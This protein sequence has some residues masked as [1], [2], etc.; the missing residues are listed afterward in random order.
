MP[1]EIAGNQ[2]SPVAPASPVASPQGNIA[3]QA[4]QALQ[5]MNITPSPEEEV[6]NIGGETA[7]ESPSIDFDGLMNLI[8]N[9]GG[10]EVQTQPEVPAQNSSQND[11]AAIL[12]AMVQFSQRLDQIENGRNQSYYN[13]QQ[14]NF[15]NYQSQNQTNQNGQVQVDL[16]DVDPNIAA[17]QR[18]V[19]TL[20]GYIAQGQQTQKMTLQQVITERLDQEYNRQKNIDPVLGHID[21]TGALTAAFM[22]THQ[23]D[24][25]TA[26]KAVK[27][28]GI[29]GFSNR[30]SV[31]TILKS[32]PQKQQK[33]VLT[34]AIELLKEFSKP[35]VPGTTTIP[36]MQPA[37][38]TSPVNKPG[39][40]GKKMSIEEKKNKVRGILASFGIG[41]QHQEDF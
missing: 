32:L 15:Q 29:G 33:E 7:V 8:G 24:M 10:Q 12:N 35:T 26:I 17:L 3:A 22:Q 41:Q 38:P 4:A 6:L 13:P 36:G 30:D 11:M 1:T 14:N 19:A 23:V 5:Q 27:N 34:V 28:V 18:E 9:L 37:M 40:T 21:P 31:K 25:P 2:E 39:N 16:G 20:K